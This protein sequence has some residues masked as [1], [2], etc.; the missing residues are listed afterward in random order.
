[1]LLAP[2]QY[3]S[4]ISWVGVLASQLVSRLSRM[5]DPQFPENSPTDIYKDR[6]QNWIKAEVTDPAQSLDDQVVE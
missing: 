1:M 2:I 6:R 4:A 5:M 3:C